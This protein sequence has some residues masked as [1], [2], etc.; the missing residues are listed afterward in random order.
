MLINLVKCIVIELFFVPNKGALLVP[1]SIKLTDIM[2]D[3]DLQFL[4]LDDKDY[5][6][7]DSLNRT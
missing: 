3:S 4:R 1:Y 6:L 2:Y 5:T 7:I